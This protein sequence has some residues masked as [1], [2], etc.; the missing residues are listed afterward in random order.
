[1]MPSQIQQNGEMY[2]VKQVSK[3]MNVLACRRESC[4]HPCS[5]QHEYSCCSMWRLG[6]RCAAGLYK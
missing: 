2:K 4:T 3:P 6:R 1:M 5:L